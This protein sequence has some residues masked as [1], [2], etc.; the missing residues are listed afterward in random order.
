MA[1]NTDNSVTL[2][3][4]G[5]KS[6]MTFIN[7][8]S[9][10]RRLNYFDGKFLRAPDLILEQQA[11]LNQIRL[12]NQAGGAGVVH[13]FD[14]TLAGGDTLDIGSGLAF[15]ARGRALHMDQ[16]IRIGIS[17]LIEKSRSRSGSFTA[18]Q[19]AHKAKGKARFA[20]CEPL[21]NG[22]PD[23]TLE[24]SDLYLIT[25]C[26]AETMCGEEDVFGKLCESAC[27]SSTSRPYIIEGVNF[28]ALPLELSALLKTSSSVALSQMHLRSRVASAY[29]E[30]ERQYPAA[31][32][33]KEGLNSNIWCLGA[34]ALAG[35]CVPIAVVSRS[36]STTHYLDAWTVRRERMESPPRHYWASVMAMRPWQVFLA[37]VLQFQCQLNKCLGEGGVPTDEGPCAEERA[38]ARK[39]AADMKLLMERYEAISARFA[40]ASEEKFIG[41]VAG[42]SQSFAIAHFRHT[43]DQLRNI[44][45]LALPSRLLINHCGIVELPSGGYLPVN[46]SDTMSINEQVRRMMGEGVDLRFCVVRPDYVPHALEEAQHMERICLLKGLDDPGNKP[47]V[48]VLVPDGRIETYEPE[49][50]GTGYEM[51]LRVGANDLLDDLTKTVKVDE[52]GEGLDKMKIDDTAF[53]QSSTLFGGAQ[54]GPKRLIAARINFQAD[55]A[56]EAQVE[57]QEETVLSGAA[58]GEALE[59]GGSAFYFAGRMPQLLRQVMATLTRNQVLQQAGSA[60]LAQANSTNNALS[61]RATSDET[62]AANTAAA[63][64]TAEASGAK[65]RAATIEMNATRLS[66]GLRINRKTSEPIYDM[67]LSMRSEQDPFKLERSGV[68]SISA[69]L[70]IMISMVVKDVTG[71]DVTVNSILELTQ[72]GSLT[73]EEIL[74][75]G[76]EPRR[77]CTIS[78]NGMINVLTSMGANNDTKT[79]P[80]KLAET[81]YISREN[82]GS[83]RPR[84]KMDLPELSAFDAWDEENLDIDVGLH[85]IRDWSNAE[86]AVLQGFVSYLMRITTGNQSQQVSGS[87]PL[88]SGA[89]RINPDVLKPD[90]LRHDTALT[91]LR[92]I[93]NGLNDRGFSDIRARQ[94][95]PPPKPVPAEL[96]VYGTRDWVFFHRRR[97]ITC[98]HDEA[99]PAVVKP[100]RY[101]LYYINSLTTKQEFDLLRN[102]LLDNNGAVIS[103]FEPIASSIVEYDAGLSSV[104]TSHINLRNDWQALVNDPNARLILGAIGSRGAAFDEGSAMAQLRL[105]SIGDVL[106]PVTPIDEDA[107]LFTLPA[108]PDVLAEGGVDGVIVLASVNIARATICHQVYRVDM[109]LAEIDNFSKS[110]Q[111][112]YNGTLLEYQAQLL[113]HAPRFIDNTAQLASAA[114]EASLQT[115][116]QAVGNSTPQH[117]FAVTRIDETGNVIDDQPYLDQGG[118]IASTLQGAADIGTQLVTLRDNIGDCP[119]VSILVTTPQ[120][121]LGLINVYAYNRASRLPVLFNEQVKQEIQELGFWEWMANPDMSPFVISMG[122]VSFDADDVADST[123]LSNLKNTAVAEGLLGPNSNHKLLFNSISRNAA[124]AA[125]IDRNKRQA[126]QIRQTLSTEHAL[127]ELENPSTTWSD[128]GTSAVLMVASDPLVFIGSVTVISNAT[129][130]SSATAANLVTDFKEEITVDESGKVTRDAAFETAVAAMVEKGEMIRNIEIVGLSADEAEAERQKTEAILAEMKVAG[131]ANADTKIVVRVAKG[132]ERNKLKKLTTARKTGVIMTR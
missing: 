75:S 87:L 66:S 73:V 124:T 85:F 63:N 102:G 61:L 99:P 40:S 119:G 59:G 36:G 30:Q 69:E 49:V 80:L 15:D 72:N 60:V 16:A 43:Y 118:R 19:N 101:R 98:G 128:G 51:D 23:G 22:S 13:G 4:A 84:F 77:R 74:S 9:P 68:T 107:E 42:E 103:R 105:E 131:V 33:S 113:G 126:E 104:R 17:E 58:R 82:D 127:S 18:Q 65:R 92:E 110:L 20:E 108:V 67:W 55:Q 62:A 24:S 71:K 50:E 28:Q 123:N 8:N 130:W 125:D 5:P 6:G 46:N 111:A 96:L 35:D 11:L 86:E 94:L 78:S 27:V 132:A 1:D 25:V 57:D 115:A 93:G 26:H 100:L 91:A 52:A 97:D 83:A 70:V 89:Q 29:F 32:I 53:A 2:I 38:L 54:F 112:D 122:I 37:Q 64:A 90:N 34:E 81:L 56:A 39:A 14:V 116:W 95:F 10:L 79:I 12:S 48:D 117:L 47:R 114:E 3:D 106:T 76:A 44:D 120:A 109:Q 31:H 41:S 129:G 121:Q 45:S 21:D 88:F 7:K